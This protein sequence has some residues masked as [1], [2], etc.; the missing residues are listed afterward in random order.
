M[1]KAENELQT[2]FIEDLMTFQRSIRHDLH[3]G[4]AIL[5]VDDTPYVSKEFM[6]PFSWCF[7]PAS[8][9]PSAA[10]DIAKMLALRLYPNNTCICVAPG[11][12]MAA[13]D[14]CPP[15]TFS[16]VIVTQENSAEMEKQL[17]DAFNAARKHYYSSDSPLYFFE[18]WCRENIQV[19][20]W[21]AGSIPEDPMILFDKPFCPYIAA[22][23]KG[24]EA[25][26]LMT[27]IVS[28]YRDIIK[29][30][31]NDTSVVAKIKKDWP[32]DAFLSTSSKGR[33]LS[34]S[35]FEITED[36]IAQVLNHCHRSFLY[37]MAKQLAML[38]EIK[39]GGIS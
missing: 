26:A 23:K 7:V 29:L 14:H 2:K 33:I 3:I 19:G 22:C 32:Y 6:K 35:F 11:K 36:N 10:D 21:Y 24:P 5:L 9:T 30:C 8:E 38:E 13:S 34:F 25:K 27:R 15:V 4:D 12:Y 37:F 16:Y 39:H 28:D 18:P 31:L 1:Q 17:F 20:S